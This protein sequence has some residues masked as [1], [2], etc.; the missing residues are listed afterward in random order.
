MKVGLTIEK[1]VHERIERDLKKNG[2]KFNTFI[3]RL[4][5]SNE[6]LVPAYS[7]IDKDKR[8]NKTVNVLINKKNKSKWNDIINEQK[9]RHQSEILRGYIVSYLSKPLNIR[10]LIIYNSIVKDL[11]KSILNKQ[12]LKIKYF[13]DGK[14]EYRIVEPYRIKTTAKEEYNYLI[15]YCKNKKDFRSFRISRILEIKFNKVSFEDENSDL[16]KRVDEY[17]DAFLS[18]GEYVKV[19]FSEEGIKNLSKITLNRPIELDKKLVYKSEEINKIINL[20]EDELKDKY[21]KVFECSQAQAE[22]YF[23][24]F[25]EEVLIMNPESLRDTMESRLKKAIKLIEETKF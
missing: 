21:T 5:E 1:D 18:Y 19:K 14:S 23:F 17:Y 20:D 11:E 4:I 15:A 24:Q 3:N 6:N 16:L 8:K 13:K 9:D 22:V 12:S 2:L 10:E 25:L 7:E